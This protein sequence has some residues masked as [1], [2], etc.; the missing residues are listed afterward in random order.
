M[1]FF[2]S[3]LLPADQ[4][5]DTM[6]GLKQPSGNMSWKPSVEDGEGTDRRRL[7]PDTAQHPP[8]LNESLDF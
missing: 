8:A 2:C 1:P 3:F 7:G 6:A 5:A 4:N